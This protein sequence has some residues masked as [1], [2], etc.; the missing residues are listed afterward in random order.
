MRCLRDCAEGSERH[1]RT[2]PPLSRGAVSVA[3]W[4]SSFLRGHPTRRGSPFQHGLR[5]WAGEDSNLR[6]TDYESASRPCA[7]CRCSAFP[8]LISGFAPHKA[9]CGL[10]LFAPLLLTRC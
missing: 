6:A 5:E 4:L 1:L 3:C 10:R 7:V 9:V 2:G 8:P